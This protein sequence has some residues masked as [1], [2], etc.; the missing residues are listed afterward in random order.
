MR[1]LALIA[2]LA[3]CKTQGTISLEVTPCGSATTRA[4]YAEPGTG[5]GDCICDSCIGLHAGGQLICGGSAEPC[6]TTVDFDIPAGDWAIVIAWT[7]SD[8]TVV[9]TECEDIVVDSDGY[10]NRSGATATCTS[11]GSDSP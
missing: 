1:R 4:I 11:C 6:D 5:C 3:A 10:H 8:N 7:G 2:V 9:A